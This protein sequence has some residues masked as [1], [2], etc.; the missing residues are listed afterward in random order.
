V[1]F[2]VEEVLKAT[3]GALVQGTKGALFQGICTD[4]RTVRDGDLF[5]ALKGVHF[6]GHDYAMEALRKKAGGV[7]VEEGKVK[8]F[9]WNGYH[10]R[11]VIAVKDTLQ[12]LG[13]L[14]LSRRRR[15]APSVVGITGSNGKTTTKEMIAACLQTILSVLKSE[16][17]FNNLIGLPLTLLRLT[18]REQVTVLEMGMNVPGEIRRLT[19]IA[20]PDVGLITNIQQVHLEGMGSL[21]RLAEEKGELFRRM[22][23]NGTIVVNQDDPRVVSLGSQFQGRRLTFGTHDPAEV[24]AKEIQLGPKGTS[25]TLT[26]GNKEIPLALPLLGRH[27]VLDALS[28]VAVASLFGVDAERAKGALERLNPSPMRMEV[29]HL[30]GGRTLINDAYNANPRSMELSL[31]T[32]AAVKGK[33]RAIAVL[34]DMLELGDFSEESHRA[35]GEKVSELPIDFLIVLGTYASIVVKSAVRR[36]FAPAKARV[37]GDHEEAQS[38]LDQMAREGDW[39]LVKGSRGMAMERIAEAMRERRS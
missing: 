19:E 28:A 30:D 1:I 22:K 16:G 6:D 4:S 11:V 39:I 21:E 15:Y 9:Q 24:R 20:E 34:G 18:G 32:L 31:E 38:I 33:G 26:V 10:S 7:L 8:A 37:A 3:E 2:S 35:L 13:D 25:F 5:V 12:A 23:G 29:S 14:A 36:G 27:F 17:N